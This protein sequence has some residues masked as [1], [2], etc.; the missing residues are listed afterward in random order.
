[1]H[2]RFAEWPRSGANAC[3]GGCSAT[4]FNVACGIRLVGHLE[5][6]VHELASQGQMRWLAYAEH[7]IR[8]VSSK[9]GLQLVL[10]E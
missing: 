3:G 7:K 1:L 9:N 2:I 6:V 10:T 8:L 5:W 4:R